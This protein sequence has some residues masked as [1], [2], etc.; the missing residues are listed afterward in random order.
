MICGRLKRT[1]ME[2]ERIKEL[3][4]MRVSPTVLRSVMTIMNCNE[5][6]ARRF[7]ESNQTC[8]RI[9]EGVNKVMQD[10]DEDTL[11]ECSDNDAVG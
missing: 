6:D 11:M 4:A 3:M 5:L 8:W 10:F 1:N 7:L 9:A 2:E